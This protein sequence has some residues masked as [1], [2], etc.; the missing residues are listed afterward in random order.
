MVKW[1]TYLKLWTGVLVAYAR[2]YQRRES[3]FVVKHNQSGKQNGLEITPFPCP[4]IPTVH[5]NSKSNIAGRI[6]NRKL[7]TLACPKKTPVLQATLLVIP[8]TQQKIKN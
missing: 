7:L 8:G 6:N 4:P 3:A 2:C 5:S 1:V